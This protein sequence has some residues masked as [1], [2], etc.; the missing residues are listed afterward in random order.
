MGGVTPAEPSRALDD[1]RED[2]VRVA[3]RSADGGEN[4]VDGFEL[5]QQ[6]GVARL[7]RLVLLGADRAA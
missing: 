4:L 2:R 1:R 5:V 7:Q 6:N 3:G